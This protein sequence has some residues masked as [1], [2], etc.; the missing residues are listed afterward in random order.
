MIVCRS[1]VLF[2]PQFLSLS[3][4]TENAYHVHLGLLL[5]EIYE[6]FLLRAY[7]RAYLR[8]YCL[9]SCLTGLRFQNE[10]QTVQQVCLEEGHQSQDLKEKFELV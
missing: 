10:V 4:G 6:D 9:S 8:V 5:K 2:G 7:V 3:N 1:H